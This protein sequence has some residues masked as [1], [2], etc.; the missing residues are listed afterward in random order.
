MSRYDNRN[1]NRILHEFVN[2]LHSEKEYHILDKYKEV[3]SRVEAVHVINRL[4]FNGIT[5]YN[6][7][8]GKNIYASLVRCHA[9]KYMSNLRSLRL[10]FIITQIHVLHKLR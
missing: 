10:H 8:I 3:L 2:S 6:W 5:D 9:F 4:N 7:Y 1:L